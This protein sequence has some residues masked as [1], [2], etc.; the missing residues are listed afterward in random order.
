VPCCVCRSVPNLV[1]I[2][3][4]SSLARLSVSSAC[5]ATSPE[6]CLLDFHATVAMTKTGHLSEPTS[7]LCSTPSNSMHLL[8][9]PH[10]IDVLSAR[11]LLC[12]FCSDLHRVCSPSNTSFRAPITVT[13]TDSGALFTG[14]NGPRLDIGW[15]VTWRRA[16][17]FCLTC[18]IVRA[19]GRTVRACVGAA[20]FTDGVWISLPGETPSG[21]RDPKCCLGSTD[22]PRL[23]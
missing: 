7:L 12:L 10:D 13:R 20:E 6:F 11:S 14:V 8:L 17:V 1:P 21:R 22:R 4:L 18:R 2:S 9:T 3:M 23:L 5:C 19:L 15:C 16:R